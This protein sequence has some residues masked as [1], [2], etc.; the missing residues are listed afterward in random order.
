[1][2]YLGVGHHAVHVTLESFPDTLVQ[3]VPVQISGPLTHRRSLFG[4]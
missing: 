4:V 2:G 3:R 1:V